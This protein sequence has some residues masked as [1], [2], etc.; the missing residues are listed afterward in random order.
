MVLAPPGWGC[1]GKRK[2]L[3]GSG[4]EVKDNT[5]VLTDHHE[6]AH[7]VCSPARDPETRIYSSGS[8]SSLL[9]GN[10]LKMLPLSFFFYISIEII[11]I[12][13][14][15][16][17]IPPPYPPP[18]A[19][20]PFSLSSSPFSLLLLLSPYTHLFSLLVLFLLSLLLLLLLLVPAPLLLLLSLLPFSPL[21]LFTIVVH[22]SWVSLDL[23]NIL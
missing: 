17:S 2:K 3:G 1:P 8:C 15:A 11:L 12:N 18:H 13:I 4:P 16:A 20:S 10:T 5:R 9:L 23:H 6:H 7:W 19:F 21:H 14:A 22:K